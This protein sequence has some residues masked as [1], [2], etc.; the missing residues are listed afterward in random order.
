[1]LEKQANT[2]NDFFKNKPEQH[3]K[4]LRLSIKYFFHDTTP[5]NGAHF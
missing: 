3:F 4:N 1:M 5:Y 2:E